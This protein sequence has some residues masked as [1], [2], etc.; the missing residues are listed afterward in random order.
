M[1]DYKEVLERASPGV[2]AIARR[3]RELILKVMP[4]AVELVWPKQ[5]IMSYGVGPK[6]M[7]EH[8]CYI[9]VMKE[10]VNLGFYY[11]ADLKAPAGMMEGSGKAL[12]HV[13]ITSLGQLEDPDLLRLIKAAS[14]H[15]PKLGKAR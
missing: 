14:V 2:A 13:K 10:H 9:G 1:N 7:S 12:R 8:F 6:K 15:L 4:D 11:G 5:R 3:T